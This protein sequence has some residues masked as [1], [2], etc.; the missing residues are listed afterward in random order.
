MALLAA[1]NF[2]A[3]LAGP[4]DVFAEAL[5]CLA[6]SQGNEKD[7]QRGHQ[8]HLLKHLIYLS[9]RRRF[10]QKKRLHVSSGSRKPFNTIYRF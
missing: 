10:F 2:G 4:F 1:E 5:N 7:N 3:F 9:N 6:A 8:K